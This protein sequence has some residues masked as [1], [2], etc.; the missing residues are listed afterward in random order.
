MDST[1]GESRAQY[2]CVAGRDQC[3]HGGN[4]PLTTADR[5]TS[6]PNREL[7][8]RELGVSDTR[9]L[10]ITSDGYTGFGNIVPGLYDTEEEAAYETLQRR[11]GW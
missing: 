8:S 7:E 3:R 2:G 6:G 11:S 5:E 9:I 4:T 1:E 10:R